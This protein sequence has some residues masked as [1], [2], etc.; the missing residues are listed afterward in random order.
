M[1]KKERIRLRLFEYF[2]GGLSKEYIIHLVNVDPRLEDVV[3]SVIEKAQIQF[4]EI[5]PKGDCGQDVDYLLEQ[6]A[7]RL[8]TFR[9]DYK[10]P[11]LMCNKISKGAKIRLWKSV[12]HFK[13]E[14]YRVSMDE[15]GTFKVYIKDLIMEF[16]EEYRQL[17][18]IKLN[19]K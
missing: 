16:S 6:T 1:K 18:S 19:L 13:D 2:M 10:T 3:M 4:N 14:P 9:T 11:L 8:M 17:I 12:I 15:K 5:I 7:I